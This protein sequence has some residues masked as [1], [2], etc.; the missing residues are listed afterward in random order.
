MTKVIPEMHNKRSFV[1]RKFTGTDVQYSTVADAAMMESM[2]KSK[3][4]Q[5]ASSSLIDLS[6]V[7]RE[8]VRGAKAESY[9]NLLGLNAPSLPNIS[10][11]GEQG[12]LILRLSAKEYWVLDS[13]THQQ[14]A[15]SALTKW[16]QADM[17]EEDCY[18]LFCQDSHAW[19]LL[20]GRHIGEVM[21]KVC[22]VDLSE[23]AFPIGA[24]AQ[25]SV[26]RVSAIVVHHKVNDVAVFSILSDSASAEYLWDALLDAMQEF[27]GKAL[28]YGVIAQ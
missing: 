20:S 3:D 16:N 15:A 14:Q 10:T 19:F 27:D 12:E 5:F 8:G 9:L 28:G 26:A 13:L 2:D 7:S 25:T 4:D 18:P 17:P 23:S 6:V 24:I 21:A 22:G 1:Y 11:I